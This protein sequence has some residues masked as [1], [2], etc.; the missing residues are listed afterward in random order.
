[1][2]KKLTKKRKF[3]LKKSVKIAK[4]P[5][6]YSGEISLK[7]TSNVYDMG[8]IVVDGTVC[9]KQNQNVVLKTSGTGLAIWWGYMVCNFKLE[10]CVNY[11][12]YTALWDQYKIVGCRLTLIP[13]QTCV[14]TAAAYSSAT[15][16]PSFLIHSIIDYDDDNTPTLSNSGVNDFRQY[17]S[18]RCDN[19]YLGAGKKWSRFVRPKV[20][21][22]VYATAITTAYSANSYP[23]MDSS[24]TNASSHGIKLIFETVSGGAEASLMVK[25]EVTYYLKFKSPR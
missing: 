20:A 2:V 5:K 16:Q 15:G 19:I 12:E 6:S 13:Y 21:A 14:S 23:W 11:A 22:P 25:A 3:R 18:Y 7:R 9:V 17:P 24:T 4:I 10:D 1:M 8:S